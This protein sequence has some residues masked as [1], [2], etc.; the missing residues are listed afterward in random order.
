MMQSVCSRAEAS[1]HFFVTENP[2]QRASD[3]LHQCGAAHQYIT[4]PLGAFKGCTG[5]WPLVNHAIVEHVN[6]VTGLGCV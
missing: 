2:K 3:R 5:P 4:R 1:V 6:T